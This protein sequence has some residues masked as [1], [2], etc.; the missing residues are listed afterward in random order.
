MTVTAKKPRN[1]PGFIRF[2]LEF[3]ILVA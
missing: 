1:V 3:K 2:V